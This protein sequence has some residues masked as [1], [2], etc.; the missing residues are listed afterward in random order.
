MPLEISSA[1]EGHVTLVKLK[2]TIVGPTDRES[3]EDRIRE[4]LETGQTSMILDLGEVSYADSA[5]I[6]GLIAVSKLVMRKGGCV[7]L[8]HLTKRIHDILQ[9]TRLSSVFGIYNDLQK[10]LDSFGPEM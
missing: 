8:L 4:L 9:I 6:G 7:K 1:S 2:G 10:A 3:F 5:G